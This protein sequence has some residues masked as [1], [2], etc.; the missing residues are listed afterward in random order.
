VLAQHSE[1][2]AG[3]EGVEMGDAAIDHLDPF[4]M[5]AG[6]ADQQIARSADRFAARRAPGFL[7]RASHWASRPLDH[8]RHDMHVD[9]AQTAYAF[10]SLAEAGDVAGVLR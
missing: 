5:A 4:G 10:A 9:T 7:R 8:T 3:H 1:Q 2:L 6:Q